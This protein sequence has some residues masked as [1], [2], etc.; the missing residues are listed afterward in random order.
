LPAHRGILFTV[1]PPGGGRSDNSFIA[2]LDLETGKKKTLIR[3]ASHAEYVNGFLVYASAGTL[4]AVR[5]DLLRLEVVGD[6]IPLVER[7]AMA[8]TGA[9][10]FAVSRQGTLVYIPGTGTAAM[11]LRSLV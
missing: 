8:A 7:V 10:N 5:F 3:G 11:A 2:V 1:V 9:A 4:R 6:P